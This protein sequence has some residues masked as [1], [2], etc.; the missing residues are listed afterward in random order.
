MVKQERPTERPGVPFGEKDGDVMAERS[1]AD[2]KAG[3]QRKSNA[4]TAMVIVAYCSGGIIS[5][6]YNNWAITLYQADIISWEQWDE[7]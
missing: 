3:I 7:K 6:L 5:V 2:T 1:E 4:R